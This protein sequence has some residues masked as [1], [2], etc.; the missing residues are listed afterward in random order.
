[1]RIQVKKW[2]LMFLMGLNLSC[3]H[4]IGAAL[5]PTNDCKTKM[6]KSDIESLKRNVTFGGNTQ[7]CK[8]IKDFFCSDYMD[9]SKDGMKGE[10]HLISVND[11]IPLA[12]EYGANKIIIINDEQRLSAQ[13]V[14]KDDKKREDFVQIYEGELYLCEE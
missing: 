13:T 12:H 7:Y 1:M 11:L 4:M 14:L 8:K 2:V 5:R 6:L 10:S 9:F 3:G